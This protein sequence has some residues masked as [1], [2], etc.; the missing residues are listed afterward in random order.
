MF[1]MLQ[2]NMLMRLQEA[3]N[4]SGTHSN[5]SDSNSLDSHASI[6]SK[7]FTTAA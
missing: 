5:E 7:E 4:Y 6:D 1:Y 3:A 2:M